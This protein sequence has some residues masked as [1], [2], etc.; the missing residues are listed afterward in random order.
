MLTTRERLATLFFDEK[1]LLS[2]QD[3]QG[4]IQCWIEDNNIVFQ[5]HCKSM[6]MSENVEF[7]LR[8]NKHKLHTI[9]TSIATAMRT[10]L[11]DFLVSNEIKPVPACC[12]SEG[13]Q[14]FLNTVTDEALSA[15]FNDFF[16]E[17][18]GYL[19]VTDKNETGILDEN[20]CK[21][22][23]ATDNKILQIAALLDV[24]QQLEKLLAHNVRVEKF[25]VQGQIYINTMEKSSLVDNSLFPAATPA[26]PVLPNQ[27][28]ACCC[29]LF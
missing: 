22:V 27:D 10:Y 20:K 3:M 4:I 23:F 18:S 19:N 13:F 7:L 8:I 16:I 9:D 17:K 1:N 26:N 12:Q 28:S 25:M 14:L 21:K 15:I 11:L 5:L 29:T 6:A 2:P 24:K